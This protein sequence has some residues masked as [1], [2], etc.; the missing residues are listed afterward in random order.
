MAAAIDALSQMKCKVVCTT[1][2]LEVFSLGLLAEGRGGVQ[3][4]R[5]GIHVPENEGEDA[6]PLFKL[7][8]G[9]AKSSD[10]L[11]CAKMAGL[12]GPILDRAGEILKAMKDG[13]GIRGLDEGTGGGEEREKKRKNRA[14]MLKEFIGRKAGGGRGKRMGGWRNASDDDVKELK[15]LIKNFLGKR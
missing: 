5:M 2:F 14:K 13:K 15:E 7:E 4:F 10:G 1:H 8:V 6:V 11:L 9:V 12:D 3:C